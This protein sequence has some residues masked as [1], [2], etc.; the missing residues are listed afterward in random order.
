M[1]DHIPDERTL[2]GRSGLIRDLA[3]VRAPFTLLTG[4]SGIGKSA[5]LLEGQLQTRDALAPRP[6]DLS[7]RDGAVQYALL[8]SLT[9]ALAMLLIDEPWRG[10]RAAI[11]DFLGELVERGL[12]KA[13]RVAGL[14]V[15]GRLRERFGDAAIDAV[16]EIWAAARDASESALRE[17]IANARSPDIVRDLIGFADELRS[18]SGR[19][20][21]VIA[22]DRLEVLPEGDVRLLAD[23]A[24]ALPAGVLVR[25]AL[26]DTSSEGAHV[27]Q[28]LNS[29]TGDAATFISVP[30]LDELGIRELLTDANLD[31]ALATDVLR[32]TGGYP[33]H[34]G[35]AVLHLVNGGKLA[36]LPLRRNF[37]ELIERRWPDVEPAAR[38]VARQLCVLETPLPVA[39]MQDI[40]GMTTA[41]WWDAV[42][43][44][45]RIRVLTE[46]VNDLPWFHDQRRRWL[47]NKLAA[48]ELREYAARVV[49]AISALVSEQGIAPYE[50]A[51]A[52]AVEAAG[53]DV[54]D[55]RLRRIARLSEAEL[56]IEGAL[57]E[58]HGD[59]NDSQTAGSVLTH[60]RRHFGASGDLIAALEHLHELELVGVA[61]NE[62]VAIVVPVITPPIAAMVAGACQRRLGRMPVFALAHVVWASILGPLAVPF[63]VAQYGLG[64]PLLGEAVD[65][66]NTQRMRITNTIGGRFHGCYLIGEHRSTAIHATAAVEEG[67]GARLEAAWRGATGEVGDGTF[68]VR[69]LLRL[70]ADRLRAQRWAL[71]ADDLLGKGPTFREDAGLS[72]EAELRTLAQA[73]ESIRELL[74]RAE[75]LVTGLTDSHH[76]FFDAH[77]DRSTVVRVAGL[78][79]GVTRWSP[80]QIK[81][82]GD[83][84]ASLRLAQDLDLPADARIIGLSAGGRLDRS[85]PLRK[86][87]QELAD[88]VDEYNSLQPRVLVD[89]RPEALEPWLIPLLDARY[90]DALRLYEALDDPALAE[91]TPL[92]VFIVTS[93]VPAEAIITTPPATLA[94]RPSSTNIVR[95]HLADEP[96]RS[97]GSRELE[98]RFPDASGLPG[99][100]HAS[101]DDALAA[102]S[103]YSRGD[104]SSFQSMRELDLL[105]YRGQPIRPDGS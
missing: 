73:R 71:A 8:D 81:M 57:L 47:L 22:L 84:Y 45:R 21:L 94:Y 7:A 28:R 62:H 4:D 69:D 36:D 90:D 38:R 56:A 65:A 78:A 98:E 49:P 59:P 63:Q 17:R 88:R 99:S 30:P 16:G 77:A 54:E 91:P 50:T 15:L 103:G 52:A 51:L 61:T 46:T 39:A 86:L 83:P 32:A 87:G 2:I 27:A 34:L 6:V 66:T 93:P 95:Y 79:P 14:A 25:G 44:L 104:L 13:G 82:F 12:A 26:M 68:V 97:W 74:D 76:Y 42:D 33:L 37:G 64:A 3:S 53:D 75:Q 29:L 96:L 67:E 85:H 72:V 11:V 31:P 102:M 55:A 48:P 58:L 5:I 20:L 19:G 24:R 101:V 10:E 92:E 105:R 9:N 43:G 70:P 41:E 80:L 23:A 18:L 100:G 40:V 89:L 1:T 35:D 60:A